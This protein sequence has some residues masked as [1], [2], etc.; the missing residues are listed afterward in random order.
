MD[1]RDF[2]T[3]MPGAGPKSFAAADASSIR[4]FVGF[5]VSAGLVNA[6]IAA[7]LLCRLPESRVPSPAALLMRAALYVVLGAVAGVA[8]AYFYWRASSNP[9]RLS[10]PISFREFSLI[11]AMGWMWVPAAVLLSTQDSTATLLIGAVCGGLLG[12]GLR[13][14]IA[15]PL[16]P[17]PAR[18]EE[19]ELFGETL[20]TLP[21]ETHGYVIS[22]CIYAAAYAQHDH[23]HLVAG[24]LCATAAFV[25]AWNLIVPAREE[26]G[27]PARRHAV[28]RLTRS[29]VVAILITAWALVL[30]IAH[31]EGE[32]DGA[33]AADNGDASSQHTK[34]GTRGESVLGTGGYESVILWP[35]PQKKQLIPPIPKPSNYLGLEKAHPM[36]IRF[37]GAYWYFQP[38]ETQPGRTAH[39]AHGTPLGVNINSNNSFPL[40]MEAH[41]RLVGPVRLA[42][43][44][45]LDVEIE[46][47]DAMSGDVSLGVMLGDSES[48]NKATLYLGEKQLE[49]R[50][51]ALFRPPPLFETLRFAVPPRPALR[52]F[53]EI[54]VTLLTD[55]EHAMVAPKIAIQQFEL[56][57][58]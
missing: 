43:C 6:T 12:A 2:G 42:R 51:V 40:M 5:F 56:F 14:G 19:R 53:D 35:F 18:T 7:V 28:W 58:R 29:T 44:G 52:K 21:R 32:R 17:D 11:C 22:G 33:L 4:G 34:R 13:R 48:P 55:P 9:Y 31:R 49:G 10:S 54:T 50:Q 1:S 20:R 57:P 37:D 15:I 23:S 26:A 16:E 46:N 8:G 39:Q 47:R 25:F 38:P 27:N 36:V 45:E 24:A 3:R 30:G 41:E